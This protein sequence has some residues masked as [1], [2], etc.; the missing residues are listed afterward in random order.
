MPT[1]RP[2][3]QTTLKIPTTVDQAISA[4]LGYQ[5]AALPATVLSEVLVESLSLLS[6]QLYAKSL[7]ELFIEHGPE[8]V[9][10]L[11]KRM[12]T[13]CVDALGQIGI[14]PSPFGESLSW[15]MWDIAKQHHFY[16][17]PDQASALYPARD[18]ISS[19]E[20]MVEMVNRHIGWE[21]YGAYSTGRYSAADLELFIPAR[22]QTE[23]KKFLELPPKPENGTLSSWQLSQLGALIR[24]T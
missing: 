8:K 12:V 19:V 10:E 24:S 22:V 20:L 2:D 13:E 3:Y 23:V 21:L 5:D 4:Y 9:V 1:N 14:Y 6:A 7:L 18:P 17:H 16:T 15:A 11:A